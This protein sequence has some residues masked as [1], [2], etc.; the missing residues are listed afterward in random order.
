MPG[1]LASQEQLEEV[2]VDV[3]APRHRESTEFPEE[4]PRFPVKGSF[5]EDIGPNKD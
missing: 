5:K 3:R 4:C 1:E 2:Q